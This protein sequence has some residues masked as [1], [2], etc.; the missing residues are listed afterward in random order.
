[1]YTI[2]VND[3][4]EIVTT[5]KQRI[6]QRSKLVDTMQILVNPIYNGLDMSKFTATLEYMSPQT[7]TYRT[8]TLVLSDDLYKEKLEYKLPIDTKI[9]K[10]AGDVEITITFTYVE[11]DDLGNITQ[12]SR[13]AGPG[14]ITVI[15]HQAW[16]NLIPDEA[17]TAIDQRLIQA[18]MLIQAANDYNSYLDETKA[19]NIILNEED[20]TVQ[21]T[22]NGKV[23]GDVIGWTSAGDI[24]TDVVIDE[25]GNLIV[26][27]SN[28]KVINAG[29]VGTG[30]NGVTFVPQVSDDYILSWT[31]DGG[32]ENPEPTDL[33]PYDEWKPVE[34]SEQNSVYVWEQ[35]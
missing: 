33:F 23:I 16:S 31:N 28:G 21:L 11:M 35:L 30:A 19:D 6:M 15:P 25:N 1:M 17:L 10:E 26:T 3:R 29:H 24:V 20:G 27:L 14:H 34:G 32:L 2:L 18:E 7:Q 12:R 9:T 22:S 8:D 4:N 5:V 13:K